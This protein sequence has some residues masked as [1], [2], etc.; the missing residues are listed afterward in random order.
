MTSGELEYAKRLALQLYDEW[1]D[2]TGFPAKFTSYY[3]EIQSLIE[4]AVDIGAKVARGIKVDLNGYWED[5]KENPLS[6]VQTADI[7]KLCD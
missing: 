5:E 4:N 1:N 7:T 6:R 3:Y 2:V